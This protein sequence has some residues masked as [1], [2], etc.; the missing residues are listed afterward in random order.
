M[1]KVG[2]LVYFNFVN[3]KPHRKIAI[4][5]KVIPK[6]EYLYAG[7][8]IWDQYSFLIHTGQ[9]TMYV[10]EEHLKSFDSK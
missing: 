6:E 7:K 3:P 8:M 10:T 2:D 1:Y 5:I 4:I 9:R